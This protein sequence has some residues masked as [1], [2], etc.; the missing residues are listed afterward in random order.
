MTLTGKFVV[1]V[2]SI[3]VF[4][5]P[6]AAM[7]LHCLLMTSPG[8]SAHP[9]HMMEMSLSTGA[10]RISAAVD[11]SCCQVSAAKPVSLTVPS[12]SG[13]WTIVPPATNVMLADL[14]PAL[15]LHEVLGCAASPG[16]PPLAVLCTFL[17]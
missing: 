12:F 17:I 5:M 14:P 8:E 4:V 1:V 9:C 11:H 10:S 3:A 6:T 13:K 2:A 7:P 16:G 15:V